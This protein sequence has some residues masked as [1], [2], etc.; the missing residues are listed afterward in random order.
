MI[1]GVVI[2]LLDSKYKE[3]L[4]RFANGSPKWS[5]ALKFPYMEKHS[6]VVDIVFE[7]SPNGSGKITPSAIYE[8]V[9]FNGAKQTKTS[10]ANYKRFKQLKLGKGSDIVVQY[11]NEVLSYIDVLDTDN[12]KTIEPIPFTTEC[13]ACGG[14]VRIHKNDKDEETFVY[15]DNPRC[16]MKTIGK[17][18]KYT[19]DVGIK[20]VEVS[21]LEKIVKAGKLKTIGDLYRLKFKDIN[22]I[23]GLGDLS[24]EAIIDA[25]YTNKPK[26]YAL[27]A[28]LG[29]PN[30]GKDLSKTLLSE[31]SF[32]L[33]S[34]KEYVQ[35]EEFK[36][37]LVSLDGIADTMTKRISEGLSEN[38]EL[39]QDILA[40]V[41]FESTKREKVENQLKFCTTG[42]PDKNY[43]AKRDDLK[44][45]IESKGHKLTGAVSG[46]T[47]Y[48]ITETPN[49]GTV[50]N[51]RARELGVKIITCAELKDILG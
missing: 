4:G 7:A 11:R 5:C 15:C 40:N 45:Y 26:D 50:K 14:K 16:I 6:K 22:T 17:I 36:E 41:K 44:E 29:I 25:I 20:G 38:S 34:D 49:S 33:L 1:D 30:L 47:D 9:Y 8:P 42:D 43:F 37:R 18:N 51:K 32:D 21:T 12:N 31:F 24:A 46:K 28:G 23:E 35:S 2:E 19:T 10:L 27:L 3:K 39:L 13:P 48:L